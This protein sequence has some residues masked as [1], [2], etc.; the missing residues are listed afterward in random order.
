MPPKP[1]GEHP[2][3]LNELT[4]E[5]PESWQN[6][7]CGPNLKL[8]LATLGP[9]V[10]HSKTVGKGDELS[11]FRSIN[12]MKEF[13]A[14]WRG[15]GDYYLLADYSE[16][17]SIS[18]TARTTAIK[19]FLTETSLKGVVFYG[20]SAALKLSIR[21]GRSVH[22][23]PY[24]VLI[25]ADYAEALAMAQGWL[26]QL[27]S[28]EQLLTS[29]TAV[30][31][32]AP[33]EQILEFLG[34]V[35]WTLRGP[36]SL[37]PFSNSDELAPVYE[38]FSLIKQDLDKMTLAQEESAQ[39]LLESEN[40]YRR[41][42]ENIQDIYLETTLK[43]VILEVSPSVEQ[44]TG[45][46]REKLLGAP[47]SML[48]QDPTHWQQLV[49]RLKVE[50]KLS[51]QEEIL[52]NLRGEPTY[53][54]ISSALVWDHQ[55]HPYKVV[56]S[57]RCI[58][59]SKRVE[60]L[61]L[62]KVTAE[63][64]NKAKSDFLANMSHEIRTPLNAVIGMTELALDTR[65]DKEQREILET[66]SRESNDLIEI[67]D[68]VLDLAK[69]E[70]GKFELEEIP[71]ELRLILETL[72]QSHGVRAQ[73]KGLEFIAYLAPDLPS[74][75][76]GDPVKI[77]QILS[78]L[79][80]N[81]LKFTAE[82][83][84]M[85]SG[86]LLEEQ[87]D[88]VKIRFEVK[89]T[90]IG[91]AEDKL[92]LIFQSFSQV[93]GSITRKF[94]G[95]GLGTTIAKQFVE[96]MFGK[97]GVE[98]TL[99]K[100]STFWFEVLLKKQPPEMRSSKKA[101][102]ELKGTRVLVV[103]DRDSNREVV[104][105]YLRHWGAE[106]YGAAS[107]AEALAFLGNLSS[108]E[109]LDA[110]VIDIQMPE[111]DGFELSKRVRD[112]P[113]TQ[114]TP[115]LVT[116]ISGIKGDAKKCL[117]IGING[118]MSK[119]IR[120]DDL[121]EAL[122][123]VLGFSSKGANLRPTLV[124]RHSL[125]EANHRSIQI[126]LVEDYPTNQRIARAH[127]EGA[128]YQVTLAENGL[129]A[130]A[131]F[132]QKPFHLVLMDVQMPQMDGLT[133]TRIIRSLEAKFKDQ[134]DHHIPIIAMTAHAM[135]GYKETCQEAGMD[136]YLT[137]PFTRAGLTGMVKKWSEG[138]ADQPAL[139]QANLEPEEGP[140]L[141]YSLALEEFGGD[142]ELLDEV[143]KGFLQHAG[144]QILEIE[145][146]IALGRLDS[147]ASVAHALKGGAKN[148]TAVILG[149]QAEALENLA[150]SGRIEQIEGLLGEVKAE[151]GKFQ[152]YFDLYSH[153]RQNPNHLEGRG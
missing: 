74:N 66:I 122:C 21:L 95:S 36:E 83:E 16:L 136:D 45:Y 49:E 76:I 133:A 114:E 4:P 79:I 67:V 28:Q 118:Y 112:L 106:P 152:V 26:D 109:K 22:P 144:T 54:S 150:R 38:A 145:Q 117:D 81:A 82:G 39:A 10:L 84:I 89:D 37:P 138:F 58:N 14:G 9:Q 42:F 100:G 132:K 24:P 73:K 69:V 148:L 80:G 153:E 61:L 47:I 65:L 147:V 50:K 99:G 62:E 25:A 51:E 110:L 123:S 52:K 13:V 108:E 59:N 78:N 32:A 127:L 98:S 40:R 53:F 149:Q 43:G 12:G 125:A 116:T 141:D 126:L 140:P 115:I 135:K 77:R 92:D 88:W 23:L 35:D 121:F 94:G 120:K 34:N 30:H 85:V 131:L 137:K 8:S 60:Q 64:S 31:P 15:E 1:T 102:V 86:K 72:C 96:L 151:L 90:G 44:Y 113:L 27:P 63:A 6:R 130:V 111:M 20:L 134:K 128:G 107:G 2:R 91:I 19:F 3:P 57:L 41:I 75:L 18:Y 33:A 104:M 55:G 48:Y 146:S 105:G 5:L 56:G 129:E 142:Q 70:S 97:I 87:G 124:T 46:T 68:A 93:D 29:E 139:E 17:R 119:P 71:F 143:I 103:D 7:P 101:Q 11:V